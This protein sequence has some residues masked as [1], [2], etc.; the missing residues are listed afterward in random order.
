M[1]WQ[2]RSGGNPWLTST[3]DP[4]TGVFSGDI[5]MIE[6][7]KAYFITSAASYTVN[8]KLEPVGTSLPPTIAVRQGYNAIGFVSISGATE[9]DIELYLNSIGWSVAYSY[10]PTPGKGWKAIRKGQ[11]T[12]DNPIMVEGRPRV[13]GVRAV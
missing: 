2:R 7:G 5:T 13:P 8:V 3:K 1:A 4:E 12:E 6:P 10:D 9:T 11:S